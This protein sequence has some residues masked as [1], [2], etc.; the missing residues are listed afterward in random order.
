MDELKAGTRRQ[1][2]SEQIEQLAGDLKALQRDYSAVVRA[3]RRRFR[4]GVI[5]GDAD[6]RLLEFCLRNGIV[7]R[8][9]R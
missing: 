2:K 8:R 5:N 1:S 6:L 4:E 3:I 9:K 7:K